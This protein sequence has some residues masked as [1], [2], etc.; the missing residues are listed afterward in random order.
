MFKTILVPTDGS[1]LVD[2][3]IAGAIELAATCD[4]KI[5]GLSVAEPY[6]LLPLAE[7]P[8]A[9]EIG[10]YDESA[11][12]IAQQHVKKIADSARTAGIP[13]EIIVT[14]SFSP[15]EEILS[16]AKKCRCDVIVMASHGRKGWSKLLLGSETRK[17]LAHSSI[18]VLVF[19]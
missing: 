16:M 19:R 7:N 1:A 6:P 12:K 5:I 18:P 9:P 4:G 2:K 13:Y 17:V 3:A 10:L 14:Q 15:H 8:I 11:Q